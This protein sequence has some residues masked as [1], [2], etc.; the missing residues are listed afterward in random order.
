M[1]LVIQICTIEIDNLIKL[2]VSN[3]SVLDSCLKIRILLLRRT[4]SI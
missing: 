3:I 1:L 4:D 2:R